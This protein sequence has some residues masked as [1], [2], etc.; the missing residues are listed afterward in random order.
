MIVLEIVLRLERSSP[1]PSCSAAV[2]LSSARICKDKLAIGGGERDDR[3]PLCQAF[4]LFPLCLP[5]YCFIPFIFLINNLSN[6]MLR[7][8]QSKAKTAA[9]LITIESSEAKGAAAAGAAR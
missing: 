4:S 6:E 9:K 3:Q 5:A 8:G 1:S 2:G 7:R